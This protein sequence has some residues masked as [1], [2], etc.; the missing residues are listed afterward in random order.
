MGSGQKLEASGESASDIS[1]QSHG[2]QISLQL[3]ADTA[4]VTGVSL[5]GNRLIVTIE[6][7][8]GPTPLNPV[9]L[10]SADTPVSKPEPIPEPSKPGPL[11]RRRPVRLYRWSS[12]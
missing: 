6:A 11:K 10:P 2:K 1:L 3:H 9:S 5:Q 4:H 7:E 12:P 8:L